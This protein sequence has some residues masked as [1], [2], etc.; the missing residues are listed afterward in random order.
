LLGG[1]P[2]CFS[3]WVVHLKKLPQFI[4]LSEEELRTLFKKILAMEERQYEEEAIRKRAKERADDAAYLESHPNDPVIST[5]P[6]KMERGV[7]FDPKALDGK[8]FLSD[9]ALSKLPRRTK[10]SVDEKKKMYHNFPF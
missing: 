10:W 9:D 1:K 6:I 4:G 3:G 8:S 7:F 2:T 5:N